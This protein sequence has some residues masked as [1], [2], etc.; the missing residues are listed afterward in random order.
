M[1]HLD[2]A[3]LETVL[4][5]FLGEAFQGSWLPVQLSIHA[6]T[7]LAPL[8]QSRFL[9]PPLTARVLEGPFLLLCD[10]ISML[11]PTL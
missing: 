3:A 11:T 8:S 1:P 10:R 5:F 2:G 6:C 7:S 4:C 9:V